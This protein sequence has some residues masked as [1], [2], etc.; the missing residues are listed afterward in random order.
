MQLRSLYFWSKKI[1]NL[2]M[3]LVIALGGVMMMGGLLLHKEV[4]GESLPQFIDMILVRRI[5]NLL[6]VP[7]TLVLGL[8]MATGILMWL[9]PKL[10]RNRAQ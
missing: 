9:L 3:W 6:A 7:F 10:M 1:H 4:E 8:M 5:H 2:V